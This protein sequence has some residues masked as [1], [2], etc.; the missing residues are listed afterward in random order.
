MKRKKIKL[1]PQ[2]VQA[3]GVFKKVQGVTSKHAWRQQLP[4]THSSKQKWLTELISS[5]AQNHR[6]QL[7]QISWSSSIASCNKIMQIFIHRVFRSVINLIEQTTIPQKN[8]AHSLL[9]SIPQKTKLTL[10]QPFRTAILHFEKSPNLRP[11]EILAGVHPSN[12]LQ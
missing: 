6:S 10:S 8:K 1:S 3:H 7:T 2:Y 9:P 5:A 11:Q 4:P 12:M